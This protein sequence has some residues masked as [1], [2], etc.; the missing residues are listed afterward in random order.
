ML[1]A[2]GEPVLKKLRDEGKKPA[3]CTTCGHPFLSKS[4]TK[5]KN[6]GDFIQCSRCGA[7]KAKYD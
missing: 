6:G 7:W 5:F 1:D 4:K 2:H 3:T